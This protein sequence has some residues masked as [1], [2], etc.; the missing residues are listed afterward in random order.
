MSA[1]KNKKEPI[2]VTVV[3]GFLGSGKTTLINHILT[4]DHGL[5]IGVIV[6]DFGS[7]NIDAELISDVN[8]GMVSLANGCICC[9]TRT[10]LISAVLNLADTEHHLDHILIESSGIA[11]P[12][13]VVKALTTPEIR[14][15]ILLDGVITLVDAEQLLLIDDEK[16]RQMAKKQIEDA[17]LVILNKTDLVSDEIIKKVHNHINGINSGLQILPTSHSQVP[18]EILLG[19]NGKFA[20]KTLNADGL[21]LATQALNKHK[22]SI[23]FETWTFESSKPLRIN[24]LQLLLK[25]IPKTVYRIKGF[26]NAIEKPQKRILLQMVGRRATLVITG[27]WGK[28]IKQTR[29]VFIAEKETINFKAIEGALN[30]CIVDEQVSKQCC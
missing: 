10:D 2:L 27:N 3:A 6:N 4:S 12:E 15:S 11:Y 17:N 8:E 5:R 1:V 30:E 26:V 20:T 22:E 13:S 14:S 25:H 9:I 28:E 24:A 23:E 21:T 29:L 19:I 16:A 7:I 18:L